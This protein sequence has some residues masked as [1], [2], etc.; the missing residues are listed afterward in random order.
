[1]KILSFSG[2]I[3]PIPLTHMPIRKI[4]GTP[5]TGAT[6]NPHNFSKE[7]VQAKRPLHPELK[8]AAA[9]FQDPEEPNLLDLMDVPLEDKTLYQSLF[10]VGSESIAIASSLESILVELREINQKS[11]LDLLRTIFQEQ[12]TYRNVLDRVYYTQIPE[13]SELIRGLVPFIKQEE[14]SIDKALLAALLI[15]LDLNVFV[16]EYLVPVL[17]REE[18]KS[19]DTIFCLDLLEN[20]PEC[21]RNEVLSQ[22]DFNKIKN[23][24]N[25]SK[26]LAGV[27]NVNEILNKLIELA[28]PEYRGFETE[29]NPVE[30]KEKIL[31]IVLAILKNLNSNKKPLPTPILGEAF[32]LTNDKDTRSGIENL[33][34]LIPKEEAG[35]I[36][37]TV[38]QDD[39]YTS[40]NARIRRFRAISNYAI[41]KKEAAV[42][43]LI[44]IAKNEQDQYLINIACYELVARC[45]EQGKNA[46]VDL[47]Y[48][49]IHNDEE[50]LP[51]TYVIS[52]IEQDNS[53]MDI[54]RTLFYFEY[55]EKHGVGRAFLNLQ[56]ADYYKFEIGEDNAVT[57]HLTS[58]KNPSIVLDVIEKIGL[59]NLLNWALINLCSSQT[60]PFERTTVISNLREF[61][62]F[63]C[64]VDSSEMKLIFG[65]V[66]TSQKI[67]ESMVLREVFNLK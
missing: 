15:S 50:S 49:Q 11:H 6:P 9:H 17:D 46:L 54:F 24:P 31:E 20:L 66:L 29:E 28:T 16:N 58:E 61:L 43:L 57:F 42:P 3:L 33:L 32:K 59:L 30:N 21:D 64:D 63:A 13:K 51:L 35:K 19:P 25:F 23:I 26:N 22:V 67:P 12:D 41:L 36:Y 53:C 60:S 39:T 1:M 47:I 65:S 8:G 2:I 4:E 45:G 44:D 40:D 18:A 55:P 48:K 5:N 7:K 37:S 62:D 10:A 38:I 34:K 27:K 56:G 14:A 52:R